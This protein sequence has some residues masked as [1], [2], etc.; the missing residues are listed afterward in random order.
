MGLIYPSG[1]ISDANPPSALK[2]ELVPDR[3]DAGLCAG[4]ISVT[5]RRSRHADGAEQHTARLDDQSTT[6]NDR[7]RQGSNPRLH[8]S[9]LADGE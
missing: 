1:R 2:I 4:L 7:P 8:H 9:G 5:T 6:D 3:F